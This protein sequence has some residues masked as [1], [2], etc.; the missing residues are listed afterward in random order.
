VAGILQR[1][2]ALDA[3]MAGDAVE[4]VVQAERAALR[5][6]DHADPAADL[7]GGDDAPGPRVVE[8]VEQ[9]GRQHVLGQRGQRRQAEGQRQ[10]GGDAPASSTAATRTPACPPPP[11][12]PPPGRPRPPPPPP[13]TPPTR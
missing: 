2:F 3:G 4:V 9:A 10:R 6:V 12:P 11:P 13:F 1:K 7:V 5:A 8:A